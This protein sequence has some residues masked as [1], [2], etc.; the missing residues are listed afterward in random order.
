M[1]SEWYGCNPADID[2]SCYSVQWSEDEE[3]FVLTARDEKLRQ[4]KQLAQQVNVAKSA[5]EC[6]ITGK[7]TK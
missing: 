5:I 6:G 7:I 4:A 1:S 3:S 2:H